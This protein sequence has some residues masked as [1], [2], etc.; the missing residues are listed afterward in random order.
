MKI[1]ASAKG[2]DL[3]TRITCMLQEPPRSQALLG[4]PCE[5]TAHKD[6]RAARKDCGCGQEAVNSLHARL[7]AST[8]TSAG[9]IVPAVT[10][11]PHV[12][13]VSCCEQQVLAFMQLQARSFS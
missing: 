7:W 8:A 13:I 11:T 9:Y 3:L 5:G 12:S 4:P 6:H 1:A 10:P 2:D